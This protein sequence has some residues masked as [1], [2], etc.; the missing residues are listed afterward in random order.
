MKKVLLL[1]LFM[2]S[3]ILMAQ[4]DAWVYFT[5]KPDAAFYLANPLEMLSQK[6][7]DRRANQGIALDET[8]VPIHQDYITAVTEAEGIA[9]MAK[10]KWLNALHIR[11]TEDAIN[12]LN[13]FEFVDHIDFANK[14]LNTPGRMLQPA[15]VN[16]VLET[17]ANF[18]YG[19]STNQITMLS[20]LY[21]TGD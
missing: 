5:D 9:V 15:Q 18:D 21:G 3:G 12:A 20:P 4:E 19:L 2:S 10:S 1:F 6:A 7:L 16:K 11:G 17:Q 8:D 13:D 14:S